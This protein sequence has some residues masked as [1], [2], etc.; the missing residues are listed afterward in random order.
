[1]RDEISNAEVD[2]IL[3]QLRQDQPAAAADDPVD[4]ILKSLGVEPS[5]GQGK[6]RLHQMAQQAA[7]TAV[8]AASAANEM[9][10]H[11]AS[12][13]EGPSAA[14]AQSAPAAEPAPAAR[15]KTE[16]RPTPAAQPA[17]EARKDSQP[18][19]APTAEPAPAPRQNP[20][21]Q[22]A[23]PASPA[24]VQEIVVDENFRRFFTQTL[25]N[26][27]EPTAA[28]SRRKKEEKKEKR[29]KR[30]LLRRWQERQPG[31]A[32]E[33]E[34]EQE[35]ERRPEPQQSKQEQPPREEARTQ[36]EQPSPRQENRP[37]EESP[38]V[39]PVS[40]QPEAPAEQPAPTEEDTAPT[41]PFE[42]AQVRTAPA[43]VRE[44]TGEFSMALD[45]GAWSCE[46]EPEPEPEP[47]SQ[48]LPVE[49]PTRHLPWE[50]EEQ[51]EPD[52]E[53]DEPDEPEEQEEPEKPRRG[54]LS[55]LR[56]LGSREE[57]DE[58][59]NESPSDE[60]PEEE[61]EEEHGE[62]S[63]QELEDYTAPDQAQKVMTD[64]SAMS[65][66]F[67]LRAVLT[68]V[69]A[70]A[71][72]WMGV[73]A[74]GLLL[75]PAVID[76]A[77][78]PLPFLTVNLLLCA[79]AA[80]ISFSTIKEGLV[81]LFGRPS[82]D[83]MP[84][85]AALGALAQ[86]LALLLAPSSYDPGLFTLFSGVAVLGL[87]TNA[88][89]KL[90]HNQVVL[91]NFEMASSRVEHW[92]ACMVTDKTR[93]SAVARGMDEPDPQLLVSR[94]TALVRNFLR[95]S[96][97]SRASQLAARQ[98]SYLLL[99]VAVL[100]AVVGGFMAKSAA[101]GVS[102]LAA[103]LCLGA[104]FASTLL[105]AVPSLLMQKS[106]GKVGAVVPGWDAVEALGRTNMV[107]VGAK[108]IFPASSVVLKGIKTFEKERIDLAI[109]YAASILIEGCDTLRDVFSHIIEGRTDILYPVE[110][111]T[112]E[113][114][115]GYSAWINEE[116]VLVG[117]RD[118]MMR[119][120]L[121]VP[122]LDWEARCSKNGER[123]LLYLA[124]SGKL[125]GVFGI[126]YKANPEV[127]EVLE[128]LNRRGISL[129]VKS[130]DCSLTSQLIA[131]IY[132]LPEGC[133]KVL[134]EAER[135]ALSPELIFRPES[136]GVM[137]HIGSFASFVGGLR[138]AEGAAAGE[139]LAAMVQ[140][141]AVVF[142]CL[143]ALLLTFTGGIIGLALPAV[144][145]YQAAWT[146]LQ[147]AVPLG[148]AS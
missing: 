77:A 33:P 97:S 91:R 42:P 34:Q 92:A 52:D 95:H 13:P 54:L 104:P 111:M 37:A 29:E 125:F 121:A 114:G 40:A 1:M 132:Q 118:M 101:V 100:C 106:A 64:L 88:V 120:G 131:Q 47:E 107:L 63:W 98:L 39:Q 83:T 74:T 147:L 86:A 16:P 128:S 148:K 4:S 78:D 44:D 136:E 59:E 6:R 140:K 72:L 14:Q 31:P 51:P 112:R 127:Q 102:V 96:F 81:G 71:L 110:S 68:G 123:Q 73:G 19:P 124:V 76:P 32:P 48:P 22:P 84:A 105:A 23:Q 135:T 61:P 138:A 85:L 38:A 108:D 49:E 109:L 28:R 145:L 130:D 87:C 50:Q 70:A 133:V 2:R 35:T 126:C 3:Q 21:P 58:E 99:G 36:Q 129:L 146:V 24:G 93:L 45:P 69:L 7:D 25:D 66:R 143:V 62:E 89:G 11:P 17:P 119:H 53:Q 15:K 60:E 79:A 75:L 27:E 82:A 90:V 57:E 26:L 117:N 142:S 94:P 43:P 8:P 80:L 55:R 115:Y 41:R 9:S 139:K 116:R 113:V 144:L 46:T 12:E 18:K 122:S 30:S 141:G 56:L 67:V 10:F 65:L 20:K 103:A 5:A 134:T 137:T